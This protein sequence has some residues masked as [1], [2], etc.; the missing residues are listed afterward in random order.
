[1]QTA[2]FAVAAIAVMGLTLGLVIGLVAKLFAVETDPRIETVGELLP[3]ANCGGC[4]FAGC[5]DFAKAVV[6][7]DVEPAGCPVNSAEN[8]AEI[9]KLLGKSAGEG[10]RKVAVVLC[11]GD[12]N[13]AKRSVKYNGV[14]DCKSAAAVAGGDKGCAYGCLGF[15]TCARACPFNAIEMCDGLAVVHPDLCVGC[16]KCVAA[17]PRDLIKLVPA[18]TEVHVFCSSP[19]KGPVKKKVCSVPCIGCRKCVKAAEEG[20]MT[21]NGFLIAV[22]YDNPPSIDVIEAAK[23]PTGCLKTGS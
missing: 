10:G 20:Q 11:G 4:G 12:N 7:G 3:G 17:C 6:A 1:M 2:V 15:A 5:S 18:D 13:T 9:A 16:G 21:V 23:C 8:A 22:N 19:E 14:K